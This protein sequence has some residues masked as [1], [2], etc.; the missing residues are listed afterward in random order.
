M[1]QPGRVRTADQTHFQ[2]RPS[3]VPSTNLHTEGGRE[4]TSSTH[5]KKDV[6]VQ[7]TIPI[8]SG[9]THWP[10][11]Q[12]GQRERC[13]L[14]TLPRRTCHNRF[15]RGTFL[16]KRGARSGNYPKVETT[17]PQNLFDS[18]YIRQ[19]TCT[20]DFVGLGIGLVSLRQIWLYSCLCFHSSICSLV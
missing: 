17:K 6:E 11:Q 2:P 7:S 5:T 9:T 1:M 16:R 8:S 19:P 20:N 4:R 18:Y 3:S 13:S 15:V 12:G 14:C 10:D